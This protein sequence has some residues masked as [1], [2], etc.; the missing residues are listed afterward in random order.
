VVGE[1]LDHARM[2]YMK[3]AS[4]T[5]FVLVLYPH[6]KAMDFFGN[7]KKVTVGLTKDGQW[8]TVEKYKTR[9]QA[10]SLRSNEKGRL[11]YLHIPI[12]IPCEFDDEPTLSDCEA[13]F[14][15]ARQRWEFKVIKAIRFQQSFLKVI[16]S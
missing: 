7:D 10:V 12:R 16:A 6:K 5:Y 13:H 3:E 15:E 1:P 14:N 8:V 9:G 4:R 11:P 2:T